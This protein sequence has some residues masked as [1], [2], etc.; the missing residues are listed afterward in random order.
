MLIACG[1]RK[2]G[3]GTIRSKFLFERRFRG[4]VVSRTDLVFDARF[5]PPAA[6]GSTSILVYL[7][8]SG[9][10]EVLERDTPVKRWTAPAAFL[11]TEEQFEGSGSRRS[12]LFRSA[13]APF[14]AI[15]LRFERHDI[16][17][18]PLSI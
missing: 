7:V 10:F 4:H 6:K 5:A 17:A 14:E 12:F 8:T 18:K 3:R 15:E 1:S 16:I 11:L 2:L 13:G 9:V